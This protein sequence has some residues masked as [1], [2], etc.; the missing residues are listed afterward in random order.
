MRIHIGIL[1]CLLVTAS[2]FAVE[3]HPL[4][5][6]APARDGYYSAASAPA[7]AF[8]STS[9]YSSHSTSGLTS[10]SI[11]GL[12]AISAS[13][14]AALNSEDGLFAETSAKVGAIRKSGRPGGGGSG[15]S[16]GIG[17]YDFHS[18]VGDLPFLFF[19]LLLAAHACRANKRLK[20]GR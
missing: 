1:V 10:N 19:V 11:S 2:A 18:P 8:R 12:S 15:G 20:V 3:Y 9:A 14:F 5:T 16:G 17:E 7:V 4:R 13:N 6:Y